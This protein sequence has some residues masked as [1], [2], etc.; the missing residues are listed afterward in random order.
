MSRT[1]PSSGS[2]AGADPARPITIGF[3]GGEPLRNRSLVHAVVALADRLAQQRH[4]DVRYS[5]TTNG[6]LFTD[7]DLELFRNHRFAVTVS[8]DGDAVAHDAQR[9]L[10]NGSGSFAQL[11]SACSRCWPNRGLPRSRRA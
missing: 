8:V 6:T 10:R 7:A 3:L 1:R 11:A 5:I 2:L 9:P 4:L